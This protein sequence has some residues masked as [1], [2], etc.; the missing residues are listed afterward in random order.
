MTAKLCIN[1]KHLYGS[2]CLAPANGT[3]LVDG[4]AQPLLASLART[5]SPLSGS[6]CGPEGN[7]FEA[8]ETKSPSLWRRILG[9]A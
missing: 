8:R 9:R 7:H 6:T 2:V 4:G 1:C 3:S 5:N